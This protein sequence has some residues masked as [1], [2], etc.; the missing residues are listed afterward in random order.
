M[1]FI[2]VMGNG[3][4]RIG[5]IGNDE[6]YRNWYASTTLQSLASRRGS[7][8]LCLVQYLPRAEG[9]RFID[10]D[11]ERFNRYRFTHSAR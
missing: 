5:C 11:P 10:T 9:A 3:S 7:M 8:G 4:F 2:P 1:C 6:L